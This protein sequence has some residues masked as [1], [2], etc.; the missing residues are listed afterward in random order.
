MK[1]QEKTGRLFQSGRVA[2]SALPTEVRQIRVIIARFGGDEMA[3]GARN[4]GV[5][6]GKARSGLNLRKLKERDQNRRQWYPRQQ[7]F[8]RNSPHMFLYRHGYADY[9]SLIKRQ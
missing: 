9:E 3:I 7:G 6:R 5:R 2:G 8:V 1:T 4:L